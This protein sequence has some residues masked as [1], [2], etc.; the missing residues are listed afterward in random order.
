MTRSTIIGIAATAAAGAAVLFLMTRENIPASQTARLVQLPQRESPGST[1]VAR[2]T[3][4]ARIGP[5]SLSHRVA[6]EPAV[7][8]GDAL[9]QA[10]YD[11]EAQAGD[12]V[13]PP[14]VSIEH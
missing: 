3:T 7:L 14:S 5:A 9:A 12:F 4:A 8:A 1:P 13:T 10:Q 2:L 11:A 6:P